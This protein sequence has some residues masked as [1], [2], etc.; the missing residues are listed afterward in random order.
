MDAVT[1]RLDGLDQTVTARLDDRMGRLVRQVAA[2]LEEERLALA[3][4]VMPGRR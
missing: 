4:M 3:R 2:M 1:A